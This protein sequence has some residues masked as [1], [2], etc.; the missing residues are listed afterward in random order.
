MY[1]HDG[2]DICGEPGDDAIAP[3]GGYIV[4]EGYAYEGSHLRSIHI[5]GRDHTPDEGLKIVL[6]Y[7][8][9]WGHLTVGKEVE[10]GEVIGVIQDVAGYHA[11]KDP[12]KEGKMTNHVHLKVLRG[13]VPIDPN[14]VLKLPADPGVA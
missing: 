4:H 12:Q 9:P 10:E 8:Q 2:L 11:A 5:R 14:H 6:L 13:G 7:V 1:K 3:I